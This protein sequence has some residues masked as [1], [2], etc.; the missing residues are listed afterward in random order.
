M[1]QILH[2]VSLNVR[3]GLRATCLIIGLRI[4]A[5]VKAFRRL[6]KILHTVIML[7][8]SV[9][10]IKTFAIMDRQGDANILIVPLERHNP[11]EQE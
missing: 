9:L 5:G 3:F 4:A 10:L 11:N 2:L 8:A 7:Y 6:K 1:A